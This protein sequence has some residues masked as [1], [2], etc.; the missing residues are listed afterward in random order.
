MRRANKNKYFSKAFQL[1]TTYW[2][3]KRSFSGIYIKGNFVEDDTSG[4]IVSNHSSWWDGIITFYLSQKISPWQSYAMMSDEGLNQFPFF[5]RIGAFS[6]DT[7]SAQSVRRSLSYSLEL[8]NAGS[9]VWIFPQGAEL[10]LEKRPLTLQPGAS[11]LM[12]QAPT[13]PLY[14]VTYYYSM[15]HEQKPRLYIHVN[16]L[17]KPDD[18]E[19]LKRFELNTLLESSMTLQLNQ[20]RDDVANE[21]TDDY[22]L[23][24]LGYRSVS[25]W[26]SLWSGGKRK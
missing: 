5:N 14:I 13:V 8:L 11:F 1:Y 7:S 17:K 21:S 24:E 22:T 4:L 26:F 9:A 10:P 12:N 23:M 20:Q 3:I 25:D 15:S 16:H 2:L 18:Y 19:Q 6:V